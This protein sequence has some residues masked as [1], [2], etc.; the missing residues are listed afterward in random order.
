M[1]DRLAAHSGAATV[2]VN[3]LLSRRPLRSTLRRQDRCR[4]ADQK[5]RRAGRE[6]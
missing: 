3:V 5:K 2:A 1:L 4:S 6:R